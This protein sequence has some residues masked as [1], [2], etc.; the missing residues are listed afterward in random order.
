MG[1]AEGVV[2][3]SACEVE[4]NIDGPQSTAGD[5]EACGRGQGANRRVRQSVPRRRD[6]VTVLGW[7]EIHFPIWVVQFVVKEAG[8]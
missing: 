2:A 1:D 7:G 3:P 8:S 4:R 5:G 6:K